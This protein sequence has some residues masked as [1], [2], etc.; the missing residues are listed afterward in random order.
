MSSRRPADGH[1]AKAIA[2]HL[3]RSLP[4]SSAAQCIQPPGAPA[5]RGDTP[6][7]GAQEQAQTRAAQAA[8]VEKAAAAAAAEAEAAKQ[9][10]EREEREEQQRELDMPDDGEDDNEGDDPNDNLSSPLYERIDRGMG[11]GL[12]T[13]GKGVPGG[14]GL[15]K[16][17]ISCVYS[18]SRR[19][20]SCM[21]T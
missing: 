18:E 5:S 12:E 2:Q 14:G 10:R 7:H 8:T 15:G 4:H 3:C 1:Q 6:G 16:N 9:E 21:E 17:T 13:K 20:I 19:M 11:L